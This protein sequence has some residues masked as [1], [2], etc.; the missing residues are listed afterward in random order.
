[1]YLQS[2]GTIEPEPESKRY[3]SYESTTTV[4]ATAL[5]TDN[6]K[7]HFVIKLTKQKI[8]NWILRIY[9]EYISLELL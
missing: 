4:G 1:M 3:V 8:S 6:I 5:S 2:G 9:V 7:D